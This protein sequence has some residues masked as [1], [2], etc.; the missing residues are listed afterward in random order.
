MQAQN[1]QTPGQINQINSNMQST[2]EQIAKDKYC[3]RIRKT[4]REL[5]IQLEY[6]EDGSL[7]LTNSDIIAK[8]RYRFSVVT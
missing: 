6:N 7:N 5:I 8:L 2:N 4:I 3:S 1:E